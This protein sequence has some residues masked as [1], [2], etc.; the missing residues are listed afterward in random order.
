MLLMKI[1]DFT[2]IILP[3]NCIKQWRS[4]GFQLAH[5][6]GHN[7]EDNEQS[8]RRNNKIDRDLRT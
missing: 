3:L 6:E 4:Q 8:L 7:E 5:P 1:Q 2:S